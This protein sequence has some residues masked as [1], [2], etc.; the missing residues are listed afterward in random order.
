M[1]DE[2]LSVEALPA[3][4]EDEVQ[5]WRIDLPEVAEPPESYT[6]LLS[7]EEQAGA[8]RLRAGLVR[9]QFVVARAALRILLGNCLALDPMVV[10]ITQTS[11]GK[12]ET[13]GVFFNVAH[14]GA[15]ILIALCRAHRVGIDVEYFT[16]KVDAL[17]IAKNSFAA[18]EL[19]FLS[20]IG[21]AEELRR[22]FFRC[23]TRKE[24]VIK[25]DGRGLSLPLDAF[26]VPVGDMSPSSQI[27]IS[28]SGEAPPDP[29]YV[30]DLPFGDDVAAAFAI[31]APHQAVR[32]FLMSINKVA[33]RA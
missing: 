7:V 24:A 11:F 3:L 19:Q 13:P 20:S 28:V 12:P 17:E 1:V 4:G 9:L 31:A 22:A 23:W 33:Q 2:W 10:P 5:I 18:S 21:D 15:A 14:S 6:H 29:Y 26:E 8:E 25:A 30:S 32:G 27:L 16:R